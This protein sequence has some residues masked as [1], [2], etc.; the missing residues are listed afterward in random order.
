MQLLCIL[1]LVIALILAKYS[2]KC[3]IYYSTCAGAS[4]WLVHVFLVNKFELDF[5][6][7]F[8]FFECIGYGTPRFLEGRSTSASGNASQDNHINCK[9][10]KPVSDSVDNLVNNVLRDFVKSWYKEVADGDVFVAESKTVLNRLATEIYIRMSQLDSHYLVEQVI[11]VFHAHL[12]RFNRSVDV[13]KNNDPNLKL[14]VRSSQVLSN[15]Y[16]FQVYPKHVALS[17][18]VSELNYLRTVVDTLLTALAPR[19]VFS[20]DMGRFILR[21]IL[22]V[23]TVELV[24]LLSDSDWINEAIIDLLS[25]PVPKQR[26]ITAEQLDNFNSLKELT[27]NSSHKSNVSFCP[28]QKV[29]GFATRSA[30]LIKSE[31]KQVELAEGRTDPDELDNKTIESSSNDSNLPQRKE[32]LTQLESANGSN[33]NNSLFNA[34]V[35]IPLSDLQVKDQESRSSFENSWGFCPSAQDNTFHTESFEAMKAKALERERKLNSSQKVK[36]FGTEVK[37]LGSCCTKFDVSVD[38]DQNSSRLRCR[39]VSL[40]DELQIIPDRHEQHMPVYHKRSV[41]RSVSFPANISSVIELDEESSRSTVSRPVRSTTV[42]HPSHSYGSPYQNLSFCSSEGSFK[43][44]SD[45]DSDLEEAQEMDEQ[46]DSDNNETLENIAPLPIMRPPRRKSISRQAEVIEDGC[47]GANEKLTS[48][49]EYNMSH[50][51]SR[52]TENGF[53]T[54]KN[55]PQSSKDSDSSDRRSPTESSCG[56]KLES[57]TSFGDTVIMAGRKFISSIRSPVKKFGFSSSSSKSTSMSSGADSMEVNVPS[58]VDT[59]SFDSDLPLYRPP[60]AD[61]PSTSRKL[62]R[63]NAVMD[64][65]SESDTETFYGTPASIRQEIVYGTSALSAASGNNGG[66]VV[67]IHPSQ[68][69]SIPSSET[70]FESDWEPGRN[71]F[72]LYRIEVHIL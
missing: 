18:S 69:I 59:A 33:V 27:D 16:D 64:I 48:L 10:P 29:Q 32:N 53:H 41:T 62:S 37:K 46:S 23:Q 51:Q 60:Q 68:M 42:R 52:I 19:D 1:L 43:S 25:P 15:A 13:L 71:K 72:T 58:S 49:P 57:D 67:R 30:N 44:F 20:C 38:V 66:D 2:W 40:P 21:E 24:D 3:L 65:S 31:T 22:A 35:E 45:E 61:S 7:V 11:L 34:F 63:S 6:V 8:K 70:A 5:D 12:V 9:I 36:G 56:P 14:T 47:F 39:S 17:N 28:T 4:L 55:S 50:C 26:K 54:N